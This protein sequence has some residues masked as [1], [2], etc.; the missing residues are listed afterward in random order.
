MKA[1][2][3]LLLDIIYARKTNIELY[4]D[5]LNDSL[6]YTKEHRYK[7][8]TDALFIYIPLFYLWT[9]AP[10]PPIMAST[11]FLLAIVV[12]PGVVIAS[13]PWAAP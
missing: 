10:T 8:R 13:A 9:R 7:L 3:E 2:N 11:S 1:N 12:S 4:I 6:K 5:E